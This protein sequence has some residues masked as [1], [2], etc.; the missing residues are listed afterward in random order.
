MVHCQ[1]Y[2]CNHYTS[3]YRLY[4]PDC[5]TTPFESVPE[6]FKARD[7]TIRF[8]CEFLDCGQFLLDLGEFHENSIDLVV[9]HGAL[10]CRG[11]G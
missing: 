10:P 1:C 4:N 9:T 7:A 5:G 11:L 2:C 3:K 8:S 6:R